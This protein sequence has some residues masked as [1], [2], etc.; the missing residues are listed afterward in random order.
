[1]PGRRP[2]LAIWLAGFAHWLVML[3]G[4]SL[5]HTALIAGWIALSWY[6]A[7]YL[8]V[9]VGLTRVAVHRLG[10]SMV[11]AAPVVWVGLELVRG[12]LLTGFSLG[13]LAHTQ[14]AWTTLLQ[15]SDLAGAYAVSFVMMLV[16]ASLA[17]MLPIAA[18]SQVD[19]TRSRWTLWPAGVAAAALAATLG[20]GAF[21]INETPP[22]PRGQPVRVALIQ[23]SLDTIF[24]IT[25]KRIDETYRQYAGLTDQAVREHQRL[26]LVIWP[27]SM[28]MVP[29]FRVEE[30][31]GIPPDADMPVAEFRQRLQEANAEFEAKLVREAARV[32]RAGDDHPPPD[33]AASRL[34]VGTT[35]IQYGPGDQRK[36]F[37][38]ALLS[39]AAGQVAGRYYKMHPVMFG[40]YIPLGDAF[41]WI[42]R[43]TPM[44][45]GL[46]IGDGPKIFQVAGLAMSPSICFESVVPHLI[47]QQVVELDR[48]GT[49][50]DALVNVTNDGWFWGSA[51][52]DLHF[53]CAVFRA[54][55]NRKPMIIAA[56]TGFSAW[57]DGNGS[58]LAQGPRRDTAVLL[59]E[60]RPDGRHSPYHRVGDLPAWLCALACAAL[61]LVGCRGPATQSTEPRK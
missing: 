50:A 40:E 27:E 59:A 43:L 45:G 25:Q 57:I 29:E 34:L 58:I 32:N 42:Y 38:A 10:I 5:A 1:L 54:I 53:R 9:F 13:L 30:P 24:D 4:I 12:H 16:A 18:Q 8:P 7:F 37:N 44:D 28:F 3:V 20:Y 52:L 39:D 48:R 46:S 22:Q 21:R 60:V 51:I 23:G 35:T 2:Y 36:T 61:A 33:G 19:P 11:V 49:P 55:E 31:L 47:R 17:R 56:N 15:I 14:F 41:P 6:V 26:D